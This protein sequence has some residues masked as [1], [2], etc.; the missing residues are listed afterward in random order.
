MSDEIKKSSN[1]T[2]EANSRRIRLMTLAGL[3]VAVEI[4]TEYYLS[5]TIDLQYRVSLTS[6]IRA[7]AGFTVGWIGAIISA[8]ADLIGGYLRYGGGMIPTLTAV[9]ALQGLTHGLLLYKKMSTPKIVSAAVASTF[10]LN[11]LGL[12]ARYTYTGTPL[13][14]ALATPSLIV[15]AITT[16]V[17]ILVISAFRVTL[18]PRIQNIMYNSGTWKG[19][20]KAD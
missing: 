3:F 5:F 19:N 1:S 18:V 2:R 10:F 15:Y 16:V 14:W 20:D 9:R 12:V 17:E 13:T 4:I 11:A 6:F 7:I 8:L